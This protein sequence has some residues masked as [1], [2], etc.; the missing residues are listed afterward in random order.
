MPSSLNH[1]ANLTGSELISDTLTYDVAE[2]RDSALGRFT[3][4]EF[5]WD[6]FQDKWRSTQGALVCWGK[7]RFNYDKTIQYRYSSQPSTRN[8]CG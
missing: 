2:E 3:R 8:K 5:S 6:E 7:Y 1:L 4:C